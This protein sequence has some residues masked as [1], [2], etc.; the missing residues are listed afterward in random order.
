VCT[1]YQKGVEHRVAPAL[2]AAQVKDSTGAGDAFAAGFLYG[3]LRGGDT[4][5]C[6]RLGEVMAVLSLRGLGARS[7]L[8]SETELLRQRASLLL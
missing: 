6:A 1:I 2:K 3:L 4:E 8:P 5:E 7:S